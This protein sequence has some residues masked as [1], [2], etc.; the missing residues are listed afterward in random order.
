MGAPDFAFYRD[1]YGGTALDEAGYGR[2][3]KRAAERL[4]ADTFA[5]NEG[6]LEAPVKEKVDLCLCAMAEALAGE[7]AGDDRLTGERVGTWTRSYAAPAPSAG[8]GAGRAERLYLAD[9][10]LLYRGVRP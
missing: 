10:G 5:R 1:V 4:A 6:A 2:L 8:D 9:T 7:E 3:A